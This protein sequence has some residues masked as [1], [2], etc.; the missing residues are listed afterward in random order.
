LQFES[1]RTNGTTVLGKLYLDTDGNLTLVSTEN[2][3]TLIGAA[4]L[5]VLQQTLAAKDIRASGGLV[6]QGGA[7]VANNLAAGSLN[8]GG[9]AA[10]NQM[11]TNSLAVNGGGF[12]VQGGSPVGKQSITGNITGDL[13]GVRNTVTSIVAALL[14]YNMVTN[15]TN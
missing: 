3:G 4:I 14:A 11:T 5:N 15:N 6:V 8:V 10:I 1:R 9:A 13:N 12:A 7:N 2:N